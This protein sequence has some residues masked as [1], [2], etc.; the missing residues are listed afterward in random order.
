MDVHNVLEEM[1][2]Y[3]TR[4]IMAEIERDNRVDQR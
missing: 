3:R 2:A 1:S 4:S